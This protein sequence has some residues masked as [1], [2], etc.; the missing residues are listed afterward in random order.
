MLRRDFTLALCSTAIASMASASIADSPLRVAADAAGAAM[1]VRG[2]LFWL[3]KRGNARAYLLGFSEAKDR[4]WFTPTIRE[5][6]EASSELW[7]EIGPP[8]PQASPAQLFDK[9]GRSTDRNFFDALEPPVRDRALAYVAELGIDGKSI[10]SCEPW[11]AYYIFTSAHFAKKRQSGAAVAV[12]SPEFVLLGLAAGAGKKRA[13]E[14]PTFEAFIQFLDGLSP[15]AQSQYIDW[16]FDYLDADKLGLNEASFAWVTGK[17][18]GASLDRMSKLPDLY[19]AMQVR[20]NAWWATRINELLDVPGTYFVA[21][22][23]LHVLGPDGI[24]R[25]LER[26]GV[27][28]QESADFPG[29]EE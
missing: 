25:Q 3:A 13:F 8:S 19:Q 11:R 27:K 18:A 6:F 28:L 9:Y 16:L 26:L 24:P 22:G 10:E 2:P 21:V 17:P 1:P 5:A 29:W 20:R 12:E 15:R 7:T 4:A 14:M 23:M